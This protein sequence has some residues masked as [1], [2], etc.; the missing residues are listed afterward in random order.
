MADAVAHAVPLMAGKIVRQ[1]SRTHRIDGHELRSTPSIGIAV[2]PSDG[3]DV[4]ALMKGGRHG[5]VSRQVARAGQLP[6][7]HGSDEQGRRRAPA[8][9]ECAASG[10]GAGRVPAAFPAADRYRLQARW[11]RS[12]R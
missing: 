7:L 10:T 3:E 9:G 1:L 5:D 11:W 8:T 12:R 2:F 6:V 4:S